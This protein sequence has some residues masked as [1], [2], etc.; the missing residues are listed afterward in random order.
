M[1][2][3]MILEVSRKQDYIFSSKKLR[4]NAQRSA[5][6]SYVTS[7]V[8]FEKSAAGLFDAEKN[9]IYA[10]GGHTVLQFD[11]LEQA[12]AFAKTITETVLRKWSGLE[13]FV[14]IRPYNESLTP[15]E[16][17]K[18]LSKALE[19][20]KALRKT[21]FR[22]TDMGMELL[23]S[24][25]FLPQRKEEA[26]SRSYHV[27][28]LPAP[29]G[30][31]YPSQLEELAGDDN[32]IAVIH[33]DGNAM[34]KRVDTIYREQSE[35]LQA[36]CKSL[37]R[38]SE[39]IQRDFEK[40]FRATEEEIKV[41][42]GFV[43]PMMPLRPV[44]LAG[45]DVCLVTAGNLGLECA[46]IFLQ[47]LAA[48]TN[49]EDQKPYAACAGV[50]MVHVKFPFHRAY[51]LSESLCSQAKKYVAQID[52]KSRISAM[53]WHIEFGQMRDNL[54]QIREDYETEDGNRMELRPIVVASPED[55]SVPPQKNYRF[56]KSLCQSMQKKS[57]QIARSKLK[58]LRTALRQGAVESRFFLQDKQ[59]SDLLYD[60]I[61]AQFNTWE[62][63]REQYEKMVFQNVRLQ[64]EAFADTDG[65]VRCLFFD[66]LEMMDHCVFLE[67]E[68]TP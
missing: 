12:R 27:S 26:T 23:N 11:D 39:G 19:R 10:G 24:E 1:R 58:E 44:V 21:S 67:E 35:N 4:D 53:D 16:N 45:D 61:E 34:G 63:R 55:I 2:F 30:W 36:C 17:L 46:R 13:L 25:T 33:I 22:Q 64:K 66:A 50:A 15:G 52:A 47:K 65:Q 51:A 49:E 29:E 18:E 3:F 43:P 41:L 59:I 32:F 9:F 14:K 62:E 38:F 8:F 5:D 60:G 56:F 54:S 6:I 31:E 48:I 40:A 68:E 28:P 20:K 7:R 37:S 57:G 42:G